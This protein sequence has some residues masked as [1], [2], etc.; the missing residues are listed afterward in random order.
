[1]RV[2]SG[3]RRIVVVY[4]IFAFSV[5]LVS[6][7][8]L[9]F[10]IP[11]RPGRFM[12]VYGPPLI[13]VWLIWETL[14]SA[15][16]DPTIVSQFENHPLVATIGYAWVITVLAVSVGIYPIH[17]VPPEWTLG[18]FLYIGLSAAVLIVPVLL[19]LGV[20]WVLRWVARGFMS[21]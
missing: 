18:P 4:A 3:L 17:G 11:S 19:I 2:G 8:V 16:N 5:A 12:H 13:L 15:Q 14:R 7:I 20:A 9:A 10:G 1:M 6:D 21:S